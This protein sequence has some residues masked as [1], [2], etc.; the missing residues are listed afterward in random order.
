MSH[1]IIRTA[2][3]TACGLAIVLASG[4]AF[5]QTTTTPGG[6]GSTGTTGQGT[7]GPGTVRPPSTTNSG[8]PMT[9]P[10]QGMGS[11][12]TTPG[13][14]GSTATTGQGTA[15]PGTVRPP[16]T[17]NSTTP[18]TPPAS[19]MGTTTTPSTMPSMPASGSNSA[20]TMRA[21]RADRN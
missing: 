10:S 18:M 16:S 1:S 7:A 21:P 13:G 19:G 11:S 9:P 3:S 4:M 6:A 12:T 2:T 8:A 20:G 5:A 17:T 14:A 15:G